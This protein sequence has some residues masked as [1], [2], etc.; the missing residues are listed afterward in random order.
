MIFENFTECY[1]HLLECV[2]NKPEFVCSPRGLRI[3]EKL[4]VRFEIK[5]PRDRLLYVPHRKMSMEYLVAELLWYFSGSDSTE[6]ISRYS[7]FWSKISDDGKTANSAYGARIFK[8][9]NRIAGTQLVQ[10][11]YIKE[12]LTRDPDSRRAVIHIRSP[13]D[14]THANLDVPCTLT[15]QFFIRDEKLHLIASMRSSDIILGL[16]YDVPAFTMFQEQ[17]ANELNV[18]V[19]TYIH[20][21]NSLHLYERHFAMAENI[22]RPE[23][24]AQSRMTS[25]ACGAMPA[26][27]GVVPINELM[28]FELALRT[29]NTSSEVYE[30]LDAFG[31]IERD[32][33]NYWLDFCKIFIVK[34]CKHIPGLD[35]DDFIENL[36]FQGFR[37]IGK[38]RWKEH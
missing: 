13:W 1:L 36:S 37:K 2:N 4:G 33:I 16:T 20:V 6:W 24:V 15:L 3:K 26:F 18:E 34:K 12:E 38:F 19:G 35:R 21:S 25:I 7:S 31:M 28:E 17:M 22:I 5:N 9:H 30:L 11:D 27:N 29:A 32:D 10:W 14:S 23:N 8:P